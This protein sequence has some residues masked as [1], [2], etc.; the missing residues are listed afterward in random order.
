[1]YRWLLYGA[2]EKIMEK[3][4]EFASGQ[5]LFSMCLIFVRPFTNKFRR[6]KK[7][8]RLTH[9]LLFFFFSNVLVWL[10][11]GTKSMKYVVAIPYTVII[12]LTVVFKINKGEFHSYSSS[13]VGWWQH[14]FS[15]PYHLQSSRTDNLH[16]GARIQ[17][18]FFWESYISMGSKEREYFLFR[19]IPSLYS[20]SSA[21]DKISF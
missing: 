8:T 17:N 19:I 16:A 6:R 7:H 3:V 20:A 18:I 15:V 12:L 13:L 21:L 4:I 11:A 14:P 1:M 2:K 10:C 9:A 5:Y